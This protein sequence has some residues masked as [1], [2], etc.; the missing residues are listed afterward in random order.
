MSIQETHCISLSGITHSFNGAKPVDRAVE[1][2][3][4]SVPEGEFFV[5]LA[6]SGCGKSTL[7]RIIAGLMKPS[8]GG[9]AFSPKERR[10]QIALVFQGFGIFPWLT[11]SENV[12]FGLRMRGTPEQEIQRKVT[13]YLQELGLTDAAGYY[14]KQL[15]GG[16]K[17]R[18]GI[19]RALA[20][21]PEILLLDEPFSQ[22][23]A[24]TAEKLRL[25]LLNL[26]KKEGFTIIMVTHLIEEA[27]ILADRIA[28]M[29]S[30]PGRIEAIVE[31]SLPRPRNDRD[32]DFWKIEDK[33]S[34]IVKY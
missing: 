2:I 28:V 13:Q 16:M 10:D 30:K 1:N 20:V 12:A 7:L 8:E 32:P 15:S 9:L 23:D 24:F 27:V 21:D 18:V 22:L 3:T 11:V 4:F 5:L 31:N 25:D 34:D 19:A 17:Q 29:T 26:W 14:P 33:L 6:P